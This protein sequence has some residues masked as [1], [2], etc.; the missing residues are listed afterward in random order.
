MREKIAKL[1]YDATDET[2]LDLVDD[3][4]ALFPN[5]EEIKNSRQE[6]LKKIEEQ[7]SSFKCEQIKELEEFKKRPPTLSDEEI[8]KIIPRPIHHS[9]FNCPS[10]P[11]NYYTKEQV[12]NTIKALSG[13]I[14]AQQ[15][16]PIPKKELCKDCRQLSCAAIGRGE[17]LSCENYLPPLP[18]QDR[19]EELT[20]FEFGWTDWSK[21]ELEDKIFILANKLNELIQ[22][23]NKQRR[24]G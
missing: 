9:H 18:Q 11:F 17:S 4:L 15:E 8:E 16:M 21:K 6:F 12:V 20:S 5:E 19:I 24:K 23:H 14:P 2:N 3:I 7:L 22:A 13:R 10:S 1:I